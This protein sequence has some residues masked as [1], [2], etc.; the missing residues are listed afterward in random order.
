MEQHTLNYFLGIDSGGTVLK[1]GL[2]DE[3]GHQVAL[4]R[5]NTQV[6]RDKQG[7]IERDLTEYW[8]ET[9]RAIQGV[10]KQSGIRAEQIRGLSISAQGKGLYLLDKNGKALRHGILSSDSRAIDIV[11]QWQQDGIPEA[12]YPLTRQT[13][14]TGHPVSILRWVKMHEPHLYE[15]IGTVFMSHDYLRYCLTG[16]I[17]AEVTN[18]SESNLYHASQQQYDPALLSLFGIEEVFGALPK[19][20]YPAECSGMVNEAA[21]QATGLM[22]GTPV[23]GGLFDVVSTAI[24]S[25]IHADQPMLNAV[26]GTWSVTSGITTSLE[27]H[28]D[29]Q[30]VYGHYAMPGAYIVHE[31]SPTSA[32][33]YE[34][35]APYLGGETIDH[36]E[37]E[38][39][40]SAL[41]PLASDVL[42]VPFL[43]GSNAGL[44]L[45][46]S[47]YG[48]QA[49]HSKA[50]LIQ[51]IWSGILCCHY[52]HLQKMLR[53]F[54]ETKVL[55]VTG[56]TTQSPTWMQMLADLTGLTLEIPA[57][58]E[59]GALGAA[60]ISMVGS[61][62]YPDL[63]T[64]LAASD[65]PI[66]TVSPNPDLYARYQSQFERYLRYVEALKHFEEM[67]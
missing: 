30:F 44:G 53:R 2:F 16:E 11:R 15:Q 63:T 56:G 54:P 18:M 59:T 25:G 57:V 39:L 24:C 52:V 31:A 10:I 41:E 40:V 50:H 37:N 6:I 32:S 61:G 46:G 35:F 9:C 28:A 8:Q 38:R 64:A 51:A 19:L 62:T 5:E 48:L 3:H 34:W 22:V 65:I 7:W 17:R 1:A 21:A 26:M 29:A 12:I 33:N 27:N 49:Y 47:F 20:I 66:T 60:L 55:R 23:Y 13:L 45:K 43:Y 58:E 42:F 4:Y 36:Q 14:W 67:V